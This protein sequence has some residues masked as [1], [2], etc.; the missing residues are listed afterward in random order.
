MPP[1]FEFGDI[2]KVT[3]D[4]LN[5]DYNFGQTKVE[6]KSTTKS[7]VT[8]TAT[9]D[10]SNSDGTLKGEVKGKFEHKDTRVTFTETYTT[11]NDLNL[12]A[13]SEPT[14]GVKLELDSFF[15][16]YSSKKEFKVGLSYKND[17]LSTTTKVNVLDNPTVTSDLTLGA[18]GFV[19]GGQAVADVSK[20]TIKNF[21]LAV[22]Y[23]DT[24]Y[25]VSLKA[26]DSFKTFVL[27]YFHNVN[28]STSVG[29]SSTWGFGDKALLIQFGGSYKADKDTTLKARVDS[30]GRVGLGFSQKIRPDT[31]ATFGLL[32]DSRNLDQNA[33]KLG[34]ALSFEP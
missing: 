5:K 23:N 3:N 13:E 15:N 34:F 27:G 30:S 17:L 20:K 14:D 28:A 16:P 32:V 12:K 9:V 4:L 33:H 24:D 22:G 1:P 25:G 26:N 11:N 18:E 19:V 6:V 7:G 21:N 8:F 31:K 10:W 29:A 2:G